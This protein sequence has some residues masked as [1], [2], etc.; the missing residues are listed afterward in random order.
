MNTYFQVNTP[1]IF[2][3]LAVSTN[4]IYQDYVFFGVFFFMSIRIFSQIK[5]QR[6][7]DTNGGFDHTGVVRCGLNLG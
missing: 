2:D 3:R 4:Q 7:D 5:R 6:R 1:R